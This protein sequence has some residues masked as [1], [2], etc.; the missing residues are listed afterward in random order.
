MLYKEMEN[1][2]VEELMEVR[3]KLMTYLQLPNARSLE[4]ALELIYGKY[5]ETSVNTP[6]AIKVAT[7]LI[8][9]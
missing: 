9:E 6:E 1:M 3:S 5:T 8:V 2:S 7:D 4:I